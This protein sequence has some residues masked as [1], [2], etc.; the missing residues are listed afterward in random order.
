MV[1]FM[2]IVFSLFALA[3]YTLGAMDL[4]RGRVGDFIFGLAFALIGVFGAWGL[5]A[6][7]RAYPEM[8]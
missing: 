8:K 3:A 4:G 1:N 6:I 2:R 7:Q 5:G